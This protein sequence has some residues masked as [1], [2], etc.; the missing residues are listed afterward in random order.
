MIFPKQCSDVVARLRG[1]SGFLLALRTAKVDALMREIR[2][3]PM[4]ADRRRWKQRSYPRSAAFICG[5]IAFFSNL[6]EE[7]AGA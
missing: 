5:P 2:Q 3:P 4:N 1:P 7:R 6:L